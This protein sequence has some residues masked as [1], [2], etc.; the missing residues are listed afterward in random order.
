M[1]INIITFVSPNQ[2]GR[3]DMLADIYDEELYCHSDLCDVS[4]YLKPEYK[5]IFDESRE[6]LNIIDSNNSIHIEAKN[7]LRE[8]LMQFLVH[9]AI[10]GLGE[11][12]NAYLHAT[13]QSNTGFNTSYRDGWGNIWNNR[14]GRKRWKSI[15]IHNL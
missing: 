5:Q 1:C 6:R 13:G 11:S 3:P 10:F 9:D 12:H 8:K 7:G 4:F 2:P 14:I 15:Q